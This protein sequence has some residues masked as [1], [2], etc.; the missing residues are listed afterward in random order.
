MFAT[1]HLETLIFDFRA[2]VYDF[3]AAFMTLTLISQWSLLLRAFM[4]DVLECIDLETKAVVLC[5]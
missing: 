5:R 1:Y 2:N 3:T 4:M